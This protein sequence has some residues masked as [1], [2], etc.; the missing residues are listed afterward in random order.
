MKNNKNKKHVLTLLLVALFATGCATSGQFSSNSESNA[1]NHLYQ[2]GIDTNHVRYD[3][4]RGDSLAL[5]A[6]R[7]TGDLD[8]W[9]LIAAYNGISNP[10]SIAAGDTIGIPLQLLQST[11]VSAVSQATN[12]AIVA[13]KT[14]RVVRLQPSL[15]EANANI[16]VSAVDV[17]RSFSMLPFGSSALIRAAS[18]NRNSSAP[19]IKVTGTYYPK[20]VYSQ[21]TGNSPLLQRVTPGSI[22]ELEYKIGD[23][24]KIKTDQGGGYIRYADVELSR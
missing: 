11:Q 2:Q 3:I 4:K 24:L 8:N 5:I 6:K 15:P 21:P 20:G 23:W 1:E 22:F 19:K 17:N 9:Q 14:A 18:A 13:N 7:L 10:N 16:K 12:P